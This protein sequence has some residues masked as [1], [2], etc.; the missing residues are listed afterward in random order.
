MRGSVEDNFCSFYLSRSAARV[1]ARRP[2]GGMPTAP[3]FVC[4][5]CGRAS[6]TDMDCHGCGRCPACCFCGNAN[7]ERRKG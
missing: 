3:A 2:A 7:L 1:A 6:A 5:R 4:G